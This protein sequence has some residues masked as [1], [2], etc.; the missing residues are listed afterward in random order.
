MAVCQDLKKKNC[1]SL[2]KQRYES[3][4]NKIAVSIKKSV[5]LENNALL[6]TLIFFLNSFTGE[7]K[8]Y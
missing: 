7:T 5:T 4:Y 8:A 1:T 3:N 6:K 2:H